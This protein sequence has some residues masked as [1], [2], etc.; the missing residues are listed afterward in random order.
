MQ[1]N[2]GNLFG[3]IIISFCI[4]LAD[5]SQSVLE[6]EVTQVIQNPTSQS[7]HNVILKLTDPNMNN[8]YIDDFFITYLIEYTNKILLSDYFDTALPHKLQIGLKNI[9]VV[10]SLLGKE[11][12]HFISE[13]E[14]INPNYPAVK[15]FYN[16]KSINPGTP[17]E[18]YFHRYISVP[19]NYKNPELGTFKLYYELCSDFDE[20]K[21]TVMIP[22]DGQRTFSQVGMADQYK[23]MFD[24]GFN[25]V[26]YEF[27]GMFA[28]QI[29]IIDKPSLDWNLAYEIL[30][31]DNVIED[32]ES[33]RKDLLGDQKI[34]ILGGSG[35]AMMGMKYTAKYPDNV[36]KA[37]LMS[38]FKDA[39]GSSEA[40][41]SFFNKF[42]EQNNLMKEFDKITKSP[43]IDLEQ[44]FFLLQRLLYYDKNT[45]QKMIVDISDNNYKLYEEY[46]EKFGSV[47]FFVRSA[48]KYRPWSVVFMYE[49]NIETSA[50]IPDINYPFYKIGEAI[51]NTRE[52]YYSDDLFN[53]ED[54][55]QVNT[56]VL[57]VA[58][59]LDQVAPVS[60]LMRIHQELPRSELAI[61]EA[62]HCLQSSEE[63]KTCRNELANW[64]FKSKNIEEYFT[65]KESSC[66]LIKLLK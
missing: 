33:I 47:S 53:I 37:F 14:E 60:E 16:Y 62:Y 18:D 45:A 17:E 39:K 40:G 36:E 15:N 64:F 46:L 34:F 29:P 54:L 11:T 23:T 6:C 56:D 25:T 63:S 20:N 21:P 24:L 13:V 22:T 4:L 19:L 66:K 8:Y 61:I 49:S 26:T 35:T 38:F 55:D 50:N 12:V 58:G 27:R 41:V 43:D 1:K 51:R 2:Y 52:G 28:S 10:E 48:Q 44:F 65:D 42:L 32:I 57:L 30:N 5:E 7:R 31:C 9:T 3:I 59:S